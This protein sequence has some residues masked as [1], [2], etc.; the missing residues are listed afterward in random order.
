M[1]GAASMRVSTGRTTHDLLAAVLAGKVF[2]LPFKAAPPG[3]GNA[4]WIWGHQYQALSV[5]LGPEHCFEPRVVERGP[6]RGWFVCKLVFA[7]DMVPPEAS[8][9]TAV[10]PSKDELYALGQVIDLIRKAAPALKAESDA[11]V[12][13]DL[14]ASLKGRLDKGQVAIEGNGKRVVVEAAICPDDVEWSQINPAVF[15]PEGR[16]ASY[17]RGPQP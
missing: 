6:F 9:R 5:T 1:G 14:L 15:E 4:Y 11:R 2:Q 12:W 10:A 8:T 7:P 17:R 16:R 13:A 3:A